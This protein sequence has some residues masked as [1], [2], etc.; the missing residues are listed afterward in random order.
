MRKDTAIEITGRHI[1][2][3]ALAVRLIGLLTPGNGTIS[4]YETWVETLMYALKDP[5][6]EHGVVQGGD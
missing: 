5:P 6:L 4:A 1:R 3:T 2:E